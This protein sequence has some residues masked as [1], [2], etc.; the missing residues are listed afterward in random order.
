LPSLL[1]GAGF[2]VNTSSLGMK[3]TDPLDVDL[4]PLP[5]D[6]LVTDIV[7]NPLITGLLQQ[8]MDRGNPVVDGLGMLLHQ[9]VPGFE[10]WYGPVEKPQVTEALRNHV[11]AGLRS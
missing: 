7:Y 4:S 8:A 6:A 10:A 1:A 9:G 11:L 5:V 3:G 2:L